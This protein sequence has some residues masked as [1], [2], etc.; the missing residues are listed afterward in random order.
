MVDN[1]QGRT[2]AP[3]HRDPDGDDRWRCPNCGVALRQS[4]EREDAL[5]VVEQLPTKA[6]CFKVFWTRMATAWMSLT[7]EARQE[8]LDEI[9]EAK[10]ER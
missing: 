8:S 3:N 4:A 9:E 5:L 10:R 7:P 6:E 1:N 2:T